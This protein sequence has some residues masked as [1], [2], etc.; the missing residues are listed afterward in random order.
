MLTRKFNDEL[1]A[2]E[3]RIKNLEQKIAYL[4]EQLQE[5]TVEN[6]DLKKD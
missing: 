3:I 4:K 1:L 6:G 5:K 2:K